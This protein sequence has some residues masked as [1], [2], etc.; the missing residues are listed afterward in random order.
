MAY[1]E[2]D[3][4]RFHYR[5]ESQGIPVVWQH[6]LGSD[7][8]R[9]FALLESA[10]GFGVPGFRFVGFDARGHGD[11]RPLGDPKDVAIAATADD[12]AALLDALEIPRAVIGG[13]SMGAA[14]ALNFAVRYPERVL[15]LVLS[16]PAWLDRPL[17]D[18]LRIF[19]HVAQYLLRYGARDGL[20]RFRETQEFQAL[21]R[22]SPDC[23]QVVVSHFED[24]RAEECVVRLER[25]PHD[26]PS[27]DREEWR[28][29]RVPAL[30]LAN[31]QDPIHPW[32][33]A[34]T[35]AS[36]LP[37]A[38]LREITSKSVSLDRHAEDVRRYLGE[39]LTRHFAGRPSA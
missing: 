36:I 8:D 34:E 37:G 9:T 7:A 16:R 19:T 13:I 21:V 32:E 15:G 26:A 27:H 17:P 10:S 18:N 30:V 38:E 3:G 22:E 14:V 33:L 35:L 24:P 12:L 39:F 28:A 1:F 6:G 2:H 11:S 5:S 23:A 31:R 25:I 20:Q 4:I 29:V